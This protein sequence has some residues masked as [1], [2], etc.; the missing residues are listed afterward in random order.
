VTPRRLRRAP[1]ESYEA[2][3]R[4]FYAAGFTCEL[5]WG[6]KHP[7]CVARRGAV[8]F[9]MPIASTPK[10]GVEAGVLMAERSARRLILGAR[11][12]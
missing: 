8:E 6:G 4:I 1:R 11:L 7:L 3:E 10:G 5:E 12:R 9:R 2:A